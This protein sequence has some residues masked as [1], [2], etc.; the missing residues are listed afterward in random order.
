MTR[1]SILLQNRNHN[2]YPFSPDGKFS[3]TIDVLIND[4]RIEVSGSW[5]GDSLNDG[6]DSQPLALPLGKTRVEECALL[7]GGQE[8][9]EI[10]NSEIE[11]VLNLAADTFEARGISGD[12]LIKVIKLYY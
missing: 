12:K 6:V 5:L 4:G 11:N 3:A 1:I 7:T 9:D 2:L 10:S 8:S